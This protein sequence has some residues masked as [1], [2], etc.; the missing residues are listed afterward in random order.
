MYLQSNGFAGHDVWVDSNDE[1][2]E[3]SEF[4]ALRIVINETNR[5]DLLVYWAHF[6]VKQT[7]E[8]L[9]PKRTFVPH[10]SHQ[11]AHHHDLDTLVHGPQSIENGWEWYEMGFFAHWN[12]LGSI[13]LLCFDVPTK[14]QT[15]IETIFSSRNTKLD[16]PYA[17]FALL[18]DE[19]LQL[20]DSSVWSIRNHISQWEAVRIVL[21]L[22]AI[23]A[24]T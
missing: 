14:S 10:I 23:L 16:T 20:Y 12:P 17:A 15:A 2:K 18:S 7:F 4:R 5:N 21:H 19:L 1:M 9:R 3:Y 24:L 11:K 6:N 8:S 13:T 22:F